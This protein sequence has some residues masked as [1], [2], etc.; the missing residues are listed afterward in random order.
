MPT[1]LP[2]VGWTQARPSGRSS[3]PFDLSCAAVGAAAI[4]LAV[5]V[6][7]F[8]HDRTGAALVLL[9]AGA[10]IAVLVRAAVLDRN[11]Q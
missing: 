10:L 7:R 11:R 9:M 3:K 1:R 2:A 6:D 5:F 4:A 8:C